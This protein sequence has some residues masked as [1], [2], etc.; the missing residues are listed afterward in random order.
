MNKNQLTLLAI[1]VALTVIVLLYPPYMM[2]LTGADM[3]Y[4]F[5]FNLPAIISAF[6]V[7]NTGKLLI[8]LAI[9]WAIAAGFF[10]SMKH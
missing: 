5:L 1:A 3:G 10:F 6:A 4:H 2:S 9:L 7:I 8:Q